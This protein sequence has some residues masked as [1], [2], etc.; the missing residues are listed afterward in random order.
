[1]FGVRYTG[2]WSEMWTLQLC[3]RTVEVGL[4]FTP[5]GDG[6]AR[7]QVSESASKV[8]PAS[9]AGASLWRALAV[10]RSHVQRV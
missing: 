4:M 7:Y 5:D 1:M 9:T 8:L 6:G 2:D 10:D 3:G